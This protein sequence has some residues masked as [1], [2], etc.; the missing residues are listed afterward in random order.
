MAPRK[1]AEPSNK[2][3]LKQEAFAQAY[4]QCGN[5]SEAYRRAYCA[6]K[7]KS[8]TINRQGKACIDHSKISARVKELQAVVL[9]RHDTTVDSLIAELEEA[10][11]IAR[12]GDRPQAGAMVAASLGKAKI[13]GLIKDK[14]ELTGANGEPQRHTVEVRFVTAATR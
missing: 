6:G 8:E 7:M 11:E 1:S 3:T 4:I 9:K 14:T 12:G 13:L 5:A 2:L 10:R